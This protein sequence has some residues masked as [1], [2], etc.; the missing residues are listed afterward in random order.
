M[1]PKHPRSNGRARVLVVGAGI[2][3]TCCALWLQRYGFAVTLLDRNEPGS[4][5]SAGN[6]GILHSGSV[7]PLAT[8]GILRR[9]PQMLLDPDGP[10]VIRWRYGLSL[11]PWLTRLVSHTTAAEVTRI[12]HAL[13]GLLSG[14]L[15]ATRAL[16]ADSGA[17]HLLKDQGELYV[18][19]GETAQRQ[20][21]EKI[22]VCEAHGIRATELGATELKERVPALSNA[23][24]HGVYLPDSS[25]TTDPRALTAALAVAFVTNGGTFEQHE[26][27]AIDRDERG[28]I[29]ATTSGAS[30]SCDHLVIAAGAFSKRLA[31]QAGIDVPL[32]ALRGYHLE[33]PANNIH[34]PGPLIDGGMNFGVIPMVDGIRLAG[35][36]ELAGIDA[37]PNWHRADMLL[38][39]AQKMLPDLDGSNA[40]R[41]MGHRPG[42]PDSLPMIGPVPH[43]PNVWF[44]FGHGQLGLTTAAASGKALAEAMAGLEPNLD[45]ASF[46]VGRFSAV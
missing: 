22:A 9:V 20:I 39:M 46:R 45:L 2:V 38:P 14:A 6:A 17:A 41:W 13:S 19:R 23:Y 24:R 30:L 12:S 26:V 25:F 16:I 40:V 35:T 32:E 33:L 36:V 27:I 7:L 43:W 4:G 5:C 28:S 11:L 31:K 34:L 3:G 1:T 44:C 10:L 21:S 18:F 42:L 29:L 15:D 8:A 37:P